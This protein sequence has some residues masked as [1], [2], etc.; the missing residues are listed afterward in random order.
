[1]VQLRY[2]YSGFYEHWE[3]ILLDPQEVADIIVRVLSTK[4]TL[5]KYLQGEERDGESQV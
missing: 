4:G 3:E 1:M 2:S 5:P